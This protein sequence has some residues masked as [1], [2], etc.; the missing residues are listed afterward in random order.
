MVLSGSPGEEGN[1]IL[2]IFPSL[3]FFSPE[4]PSHSVTVQGEGRGVR[5]EVEKGR[6]LRFHLW[7]AGEPVRVL[8]TGGLKNP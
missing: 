1:L 3:F 5:E 6:V 2:K 4:V 7:L 8:Q